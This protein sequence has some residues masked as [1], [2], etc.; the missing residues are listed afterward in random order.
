MLGRSRAQP[1]RKHAMNSHASSLA[2]NRRNF[3]KSASLAAAGAVAATRAVGQVVRDW[4]GTTPTRYP[5][6]DVV[7]L[8]PRFDKYKLGNSPV[9]R[10]Y[11][12][13][14]MLWAEGPAW[15]AA[16]RYL[17]WSDIPN[18]VQL[19][20][21]EDDG[22]VTTFRHPAGN[23]NGNTFDYQGR[24]LACEHGNRRVVRYEIGRAHV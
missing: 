15:N 3:L 6:P 4:T 19:R 21:I 11:H 13:P 8:D 22:R 14:E 9:Q 24:Q 7:I 12:N 16:G 5:D 23:S 18:D 1:L 20:W 2:S 10:L 17:L